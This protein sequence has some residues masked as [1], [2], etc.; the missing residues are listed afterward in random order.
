MRAPGRLNEHLDNFRM[1]RL[2][3]IYLPEPTQAGTPSGAF[4]DIG[5]NDLSA[6]ALDSF[7]PFAPLGTLQPLDLDS[8][9]RQA[10]NSSD[11]ARHDGVSATVEK[12][13]HEAF[14]YYL[15]SAHP[16]M[17]P[18]DRL[19]LVEQS[20]LE[21][22]LATMKWTGALFLK[23]SATVQDEFLRQA[24]R[25][26]YNK[27]APQDGFLVQA[28]VLFC[29]VLDGSGRREEARRVLSD[30]KKLALTIGLNKRDFARNH[31]RGLLVLEESWRR[32]W[33]DL[34]TVDALMAAVHQ[35]TEFTLF[36]ETYDVHLPCEEEE[37]LSGVS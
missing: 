12:D 26:V 10:V 3:D 36:D 7:E 21:P 31:G 18:R 33:W 19:H 11:L 23:V 16:F 5:Q 15:F 35:T 22:L 2:D 8:Y 13:C 27:S 4:S 37:Y 28:M 17:L 1:D 20:L 9:N 25:S 14:Y 24:F 29:V 6:D 34:F 32:T 30:A